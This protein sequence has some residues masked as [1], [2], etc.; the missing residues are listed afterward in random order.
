MLQVLQETEIAENHLLSAI[1][2]ALKMLL[3][4]QFE[5]VYRESNYC[6]NILARCSLEQED[7]YVVFEDPPLAVIRQLNQDCMGITYP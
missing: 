7:L 5:H 6:A 2:E 4:I 1:F 3:T